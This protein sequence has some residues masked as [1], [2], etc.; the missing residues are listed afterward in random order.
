MSFFLL[1]WPEELFVKI[2]QET[3]QNA[4]QCI[5]TK[6]EPSWYETTC[7]EMRAFVALNVLFGI[8]ALPEMRLHW[9][10]DPFLGVRTIQKIMTRNH[11]KKICQYLHLN[12]RENM[13]PREDPDYDKLFK[14]QP[15]LESVSVTFC[16][17]YRPSKFVSVDEGIVKYKGRLGFK[18]YMLLKPAKQG[19]KR[20][21]LT[22]CISWDFE[23][24]T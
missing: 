7:E 18:Q 8:K 13:L 15:L 2:V 21:F 10:K 6:P 19:I 17:E 11:F 1:L 24:L 23:A 3:N 22:V 12:N 16:G 5:R 9:S 20:N 14:V 4:E